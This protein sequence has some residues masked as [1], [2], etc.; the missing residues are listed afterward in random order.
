[1][2]GYFTY[3]QLAS[4][5]CKVAGFQLATSREDFS[6]SKSKKSLSTAATPRLR[7]EQDVIGTRS[8]SSA[9]GADRCWFEL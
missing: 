2:G 9:A 1:V 8:G 7:R 4:T 6:G 5:G 3:T